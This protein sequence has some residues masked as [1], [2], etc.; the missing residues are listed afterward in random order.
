[1]GVRLAA[2]Q[3]YTSCKL[4]GV[5]YYLFFN[6]R[7]FQPGSLLQP[8]TAT[9]QDSPIQLVSSRIRFLS[10]RAKVSQKMI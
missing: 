5:I 3:L 8:T 4:N 2:A 1:M 10:L 9:F 6:V 7:G